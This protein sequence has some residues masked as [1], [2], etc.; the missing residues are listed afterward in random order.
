MILAIFPPWFD[1]GKKIWYNYTI[2]RGEK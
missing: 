1:K 2:G